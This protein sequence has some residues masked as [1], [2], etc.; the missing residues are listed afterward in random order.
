MDKAIYCWSVEVF[1]LPVAVTSVISFLKRLFSHGRDILDEHLQC[2]N[3][4]SPGSFLRSK[5]C[6]VML[7]Q[8]VLYLTTSKFSEVSRKYSAI[9]M[10]MQG[11]VCLHIMTADETKAKVS[12]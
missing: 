5:P 7:F 8:I 4:F 2:V 9:F 10:F 12:H 6:L 1:G 3:I 11:M